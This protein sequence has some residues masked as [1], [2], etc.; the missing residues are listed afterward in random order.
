MR[1][2]KH[3]GNHITVNTLAEL[4]KAKKYQINLSNEKK[5]FGKIKIFL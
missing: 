4:E 1:T 2:F 5:T 3:S